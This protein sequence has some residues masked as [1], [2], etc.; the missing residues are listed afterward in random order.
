MAKAK[1]VAVPSD[2]DKSKNDSKKVTNKQILE[3]LE[4]A[5]KDDIK[6]TFFAKEYWTGDSRDGC[7]LN[8][9]GYHYFRLTTTG[10]I[11]EAFEYYE[12]EEGKEFACPLPEMLNVNWLQD[13]GFEDFEA[14]DTIKEYDFLQ[15]KDLAA[16]KRPD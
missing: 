14:L 12:S 9:D 3:T 13:L 8:G 7:L 1:K 16:G 10:R 4:K 11:L 5:N 15:V 2:S 6:Q